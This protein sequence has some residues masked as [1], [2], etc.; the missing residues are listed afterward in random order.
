MNDLA[1]TECCKGKELKLSPA[2]VPRRPRSGRTKHAVDPGTQGASEEADLIRRAAEVFS[3]EH[4]ALRRRV[5]E[6]ER[7]VE[8]LRKQVHGERP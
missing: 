2:S 3:S 8:S 6:L 7:E 5:K 1:D 4:V